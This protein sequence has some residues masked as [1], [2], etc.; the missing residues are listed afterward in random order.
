LTVAGMF[1]VMF[2]LDWR[3]GLISLATMPFL[4]YSLF[5]LYRKTKASVKTQRRQ[6]GKVASRMSEVLSA[7]PLVQAFAREK[8]EEEQFD[9]VTAETVRERD[10]KSTRL[11]SSHGSISYAVFC[12]KKKIK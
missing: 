3:I 7:I 8:Y 2:T 4:S 1:A 10:R 11:N 5:H 6:E 12:L 9:A